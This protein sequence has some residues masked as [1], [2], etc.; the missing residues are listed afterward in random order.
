MA[1]EA[2]SN[3]TDDVL[4]KLGLMKTG[5]RVSLRA[6]CQTISVGEREVKSS[7]SNKRNLLE[8]FLSKKKKRRQSS[9]QVATTYSDIKVAKEKTRKIQL[10][11]LHYNGKTG[12]VPVCEVA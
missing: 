2:V 5:D 4:E 12:K 11:W 7:D 6:F 3:A 8:A 10:G 1:V 9:K